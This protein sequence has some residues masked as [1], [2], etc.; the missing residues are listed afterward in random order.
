MDIRGIRTLGEML[1]GNVIPPACLLRSGFDHVEVLVQ[2]KG[3]VSWYCTEVVKNYPNVAGFGY[4]FLG[5]KCYL[6]QC[7]SGCRLKLQDNHEII[8]TNL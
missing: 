6:R 2:E 4:E 5:G 1:M 7:G 3:G 8:D